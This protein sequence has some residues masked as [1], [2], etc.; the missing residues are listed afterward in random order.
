MKA[1]SATT[2]RVLNYPE[3]KE[4]HMRCSKY[5]EKCVC[6]MSYCYTRNEHLDPSRFL[7]RTICISLKNILSLFL[8]SSEF[9]SRC[10]LKSVIITR[11]ICTMRAHMYG[12]AR[13]FFLF[14]PVHQLYVSYLKCT[15]ANGIKWFS[16]LIKLIS[17]Q[18]VCVCVCMHVCVWTLIQLYMVIFAFFLLPFIYIIINHNIN[19]VVYYTVQQLVQLFW[20]LLCSF[21]LEHPVNSQL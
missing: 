9:I 17:I 1:F 13:A 12:C 11:T 19:I 21:R 18:Y 3:S 8:S 16:S 4:M 15:M 10:I 5:L 20:L 14:F 6:V 2:S 7:P